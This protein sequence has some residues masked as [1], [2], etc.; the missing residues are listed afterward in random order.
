MMKYWQPMRTAFS[1]EEG[2]QKNYNGE[3]AQIISTKDS[4]RGF[5]VGF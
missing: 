2:C 3:T 5:Y 4:D 1:S